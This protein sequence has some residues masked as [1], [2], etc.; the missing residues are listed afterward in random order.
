MSKYPK[1]Y[2]FCDAGCRWETVHKRDFLQSATLFLC[3]SVDGAFTLEKEKKYRVYKSTELGD[4]KYGLTLKFT[5][6]YDVGG[7]IKTVTVT[8]AIDDSVEGID[9]TN[10]T[11]IE[12]RPL[13]FLAGYYESVVLWWYSIDIG[14][15][16]K[17][18]ELGF[19]EDVDAVIE[20]AVTLEGAKVCCEVNEYAE[21]SQ[22]IARLEDLAQQTG[23]DP[24]AAMS[25]NAITGAFERYT[26]AVNLYN[27]NIQRATIND[28]VLTPYKSRIATGWFIPL[29]GATAV[30]LSADLGY[31][32][33]AEFYSEPYEKDYIT[34]LEYAG[35]DEGGWGTGTHAIH[36]PADAKYMRCVARK[37]DNS[38][39]SDTEYMPM[40]AQ[41][42]FGYFAVDT[43][44]VK[45]FD[46]TELGLPSIGGVGET[47]VATPD[48]T[49]IAQALQAGTVRFRL[50]VGQNTIEIQTANACMPSNG[51]YW[52]TAFSDDVITGTPLMLIICVNNNNGYNEIRASISTIG[53]VTSETVKTFDLVELGLPPIEIDDYGVDVE[54]DTT[55]I[56]Q[57]LQ[58]GTVRFRVNF[59]HYEEG[60]TIEVQPANVFVASDGVYW[61]TAISEVSSR[62]AIL[63]IRIA[64]YDTTKYIRANIS[65]LEEKNHALSPST[66]DMTAF[67]TEGK[68]VETYRTYGGDTIQKTTTMEFDS[69]GNPV[70]I[71]SDTG[72]ETTLTW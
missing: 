40:Y 64:N 24:N 17:T 59:A 9:A 29:N 5:S 60:T 51:V 12:I 70:K 66:I 42:V 57:A 62:P 22:I 63:T 35:L 48:T 13:K 11:Y 50:K 54:T 26:G 28:G 52:C 65:L 45:T 61:C 18:F 46:L 14:G 16:E 3:D 56:A 72:F 2:S 32:F 20:C 67:E 38:D 41:L 21:P 25:Q 33:G 31:C 6:T 23:N 27:Y 58:D 37:L 43:A 71:I 1:I 47:V 7:E 30:I 15:V 36:I 44:T 53:G 19:G 69:N 55:E 34:D 4:A 49:E 10:K 68:I 39:I 8:Y